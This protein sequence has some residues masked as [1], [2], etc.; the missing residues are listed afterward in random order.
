VV[1][2]VAAAVAAAAEQDGVARKQISAPADEPAN[3]Y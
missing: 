2:A 3:L 1:T